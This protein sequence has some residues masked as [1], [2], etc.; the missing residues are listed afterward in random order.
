MDIE[1]I[2]KVY[3]VVISEEQAKRLEAI[4]RQ[5][6]GP[7]YRLTFDFPPP[8]LSDEEMAEELAQ[9]ERDDDMGVEP[10]P[11]TYTTLRAQTLEAARAEAEM[12]W[13]N[14]PHTEAIGYAIWCNEWS[15]V[16]SFSLN[17]TA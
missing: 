7:P 14:R 15:C 1:R 13:R 8:V 9:A 10:D 6:K 12:R 17:M 4:Q 3:G 16:Y 5:A 11:L 2:R